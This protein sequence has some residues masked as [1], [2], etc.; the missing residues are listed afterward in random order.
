M[1]G[2]VRGKPRYTFGP[3][4]G[5]CVAILGPDKSVKVHGV[6]PRGIRSVSSYRQGSR[7]GTLSC[8]H[9]SS[10]DT[11]VSQYGVLETPRTR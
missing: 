8:L 7:Y 1:S 9:R 11:R 2:Y 10:D 5:S 3:T 4:V 6:W